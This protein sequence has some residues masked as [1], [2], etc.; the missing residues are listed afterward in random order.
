[1]KMPA[2]E[3][4]AP[5]NRETKEVKA[6]RALVEGRVAVETVRPGIVLAWVRC[7][8]GHVH[9]P[10]WEAAHGWQCDCSAPRGTPCYHAEAVARIVVL[11]DVEWGMSGPERP[12]EGVAR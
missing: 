3:I 10:Q 9:H 6:L 1:M 2:I 5:T 4:V 8:H 11:P 12:E 7:T